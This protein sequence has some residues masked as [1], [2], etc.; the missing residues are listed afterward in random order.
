MRSPAF[1]SARV[2]IVTGVGLGTLLVALWLGEAPAAGV[3]AAGGGGKSTGAG[4]TAGQAN[5]AGKATSSAKA[6]VTVSGETAPRKAAPAGAK[7][8]DEAAGLQVMSEEALDPAARI[9]DSPDYK[10]QLLVPGE[11]GDAYL[12][13]LKAK[14]YSVIPAASLSWTPDDL[15]VPPDPATAAPGGGYGTDGGVVSFKAGG[16]AWMIQPEPPLVGKVSLQQLREDKPDYVHAAARYHPDPAAIKVLQGVANDTQIVVF[17]GTWCTYCKHWL[18]RLLKT[19]ETVNNP[20]ITPEF[21]GLS[22]DQ[23][24]PAD[25]I[26]QYGV[27]QTPTFIVLQGGKELGR[28]E[29]NPKAT[30]EG[31]LASI[32]SR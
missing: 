18:P 21:V 8:W 22:E 6:V 20:K 13:D 26:R 3:G 19:L 25:A 1:V 4:N 23:K 29:E 16:K 14:T 9:F 17:F 10:Q 27:T 31:D 28:I 7:G 15:P 2:K 11:G 5:A 32:L 12:F 24:E 30:V